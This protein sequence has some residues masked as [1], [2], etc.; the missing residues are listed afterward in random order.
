MM[1]QNYKAV[2]IDDDASAADH[3]L[4]ALQKYPFI[5]VENLS[6]TAAAG[7][8]YIEKIQPD[9][10]F[11][12]IELPDING[13]E[14]LELLKETVD[15]EMQV[16]FFT[17]YDKYMLHAIRQSAFDYLL[18]PIEPDEL[19]K[20]IQ[21]FLQL[22]EERLLPH[23]IVPP[24]LRYEAG[25]QCGTSFM[26]S[27]PTNDIFVLHPM[28]IG[29]FQYNSERKLWEIILKDRPS[30]LMKKSTNAGNIKAYA[31]YFVQINQ[32][33]ILNIKYLVML[34]NNRCV[35]YPPF[36]G[37][38]DLVVTRKYRKDL[39]DCFFQL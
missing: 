3:L 14:F 10:L 15:W 17:A 2:I 4:M 1:E 28:D 39:M 26:V 38:T 8:R 35:L 18:K 30:L 5:S 24:A 27:T 16:V 9:L 7:K 21:R 12:D 29:F 20:V 37:Y 32:S 6:R 36:D 13:T 25:E 23:S 11:L 19:D 22:R 31:P 33:Y 34:Q